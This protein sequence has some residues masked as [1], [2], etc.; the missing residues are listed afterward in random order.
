MPDEKAIDGFI[1]INKSTER[2]SFETI[3]HIKKII[4]AK[5]IGHA[6]TLDKNAS[7]LLIAALGRSTKLLKYLLKLPKKYTAEIFFGRQTNTDDANGTEIKSYS[8][9]IKLENILKL[10]PDFTGV[11]EQTPPLFSAVHIDG[12]RSYKLALENK[13]ITPPTKKV[14]IKQIDFISYEASIL[15]IAVSCSSG[16]YIR[17]IARDLGI[18]TGYCGYLYSLVRTS[19]NDF[20]LNKAF[21]EEDIKSG[22]YKTISPFDALSM[23][24][25]IEIKEEFIK[26]I[27]NGFP[28]N[29]SWFKENI[30]IKKGALKI[31]SCKELIAVIINDNGK[32]SYDL[33]Y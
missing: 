4:S 5:K 19:I 12:K 27:K 1:L 29:E 25:P 30:L 21:S 15:K 8:G 20:D 22:N 31:H 10:L 2:T 24:D 26:N 11:I 16:T 3:N 6:G 28:V 14:E 13:E 7:G 32:L 23:L 9:E 17:S 33:V 18:K